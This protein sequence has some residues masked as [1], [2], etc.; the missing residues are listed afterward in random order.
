METKVIKLSVMSKRWIVFLGGLLLFSSLCAQENIEQENEEDIKLKSTEVLLVGEMNVPLI[1]KVGDDLQT[2]VIL[3][4][5]VKGKRSRDMMIYAPGYHMQLLEDPVGTNKL[6]IG[7]T[8][9]GGLIGLATASLVD[10]MVTNKK[11]KK[12]VEEVTD[13]IEGYHEYRIELQPSDVAERYFTDIAQ[14]YF[15]KK[16]YKD[17]I[18]YADSMLRIHPKD[19]I[20]LMVSQNAE[21]AISARK[22]KRKRIWRNIG[23]VAETTLNVGLVVANTFSNNGT[24][25][26]PVDNVSFTSDEPEYDNS[27]SSNEQEREE[28]KKKAK[29]SKKKADFLNS[30]GYSRLTKAYDGYDNQLVRMQTY[31]ENYYDDN[32]RKKIQKEMKRI[33]EEIKSRGFEI[34]KSP[35]E[36]WNGR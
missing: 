34:P 24:S 11:R 27:S 26:V 22:E 33:R 14:Y 28:L 23:K 6:K 3:P 5:V 16:K 21:A 12:D 4:S 2:N 36:D 25:T 9:A 13:T 19:E 10:K 29:E 20:A 32:E 30:R 17:A 1:V 35:R 15:D 31:P 8:L 7:A 18:A